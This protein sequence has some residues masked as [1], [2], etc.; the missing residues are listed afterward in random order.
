MDPNRLKLWATSIYILI[1]LVFLFLSLFIAYRLVRRLIKFL[2]ARSV[3]G[4]NARVRLVTLAA[5]AVLFSDVLPALFIALIGVFTSLFVEGSAALIENWRSNIGFCEDATAIFK[6]VGPMGMGFMQVVTNAIATSFNHAVSI[7]VHRMLLLFAT[8]A[9][10]SYVVTQAQQLEED[11]PGSLKIRSWLRAG[12]LHRDSPVLANVVFFLILAIGGYLSTAAIAAIPGLQEKS[13]VFQEVGPERLKSQLEESL[14]VFD[15]YPT[16]IGTPDPFA[17]LT[18]YLASVRGEQPKTG[19][20]KTAPAPTPGENTQANANNN[21]APKPSPTQNPGNSNSNTNPV[22]GQANTNSQNSNSGASGNA[23]ANANPEPSNQAT[24]QPSPPSEIVLTNLGLIISYRS[25]DRTELIQTYKKLLADI[26]S[27]QKSAKNSAVQSY[28]VGNL[29]RKGNK[30]RVQYFL[31]INEWFNQRSAESDKEL[32]DCLTGI[33][34]LDNNWQTWSDN[35]AT[36][37]KNGSY[38]SESILSTS[39]ILSAPYLQALRACPISISLEA[40]PPKRPQLGESSYLGPFGFV[41]SWL[42]RT[43]SLP[44][45]LITGLL[46]FGLLGSAC[47][48]FVRERADKR[49]AATSA[50]RIGAGVETLPA[51]SKG[52][53]VNDLTGVIIRGLSAAVVVFLAVEGGLA[54]FASGGSEPNPYV[55]L[56]TCLI[57]AVFS[58]RVWAWAEEHLSAQLGSKEKKKLK[59]PQSED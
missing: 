28:E 5:A 39:D 51:Q 36:L 30:E 57:G 33:Q 27:A 19:T 58:E 22:S 32:N 41:A 55:L 56:L 4:G 11:S 26:K 46:G 14:S 59:T 17:K 45:A 1:S 24:P 6:C 3:F 12:Y 50:G 23:S 21:S 43:E 7:P 2:F 16:E 40:S 18:A 54:I 9:L 42:L 37:I 29:D 49:L 35:V 34:N 15:K 53:L 38:N 10:L 20:E 8:W 31:A 52:R 44:L 48:T 25:S 13:A 47:S